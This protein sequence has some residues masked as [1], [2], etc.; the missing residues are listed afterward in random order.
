MEPEDND[1]RLGLGN[2]E[3]NVVLLAA[4][5]KTKSAEQAGGKDSEIPP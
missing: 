1:V 2:C 5:K 3:L 4:K